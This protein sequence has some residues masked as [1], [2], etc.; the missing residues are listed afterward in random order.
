[1]HVTTMFC[2]LLRSWQLSQ[3]LSH[4]SLRGWEMGSG[5]LL[6][7][8]EVGGCAQE[9]LIGQHELVMKLKDKRKR[10][11]SSI[12]ICFAFKWQREATLCEGSEI[13]SPEI[14]Q[15]VNRKHLGGQGSC[16]SSSWR[17][18]NNLRVGNG[19]SMC[20][21]QLSCC[22]GNRLHALASG[23]WGCWPRVRQFTAGVGLLARRISPSKLS[24][25]FLTSP[26]SACA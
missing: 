23:P 1:M 10:G 24:S 6:V 21:H 15:G 18:W 25:D 2:M 12:S 9:I 17:I 22:W 16:G 26:T 3:Q 5:A 13:T 8:G 4:T 20:S 19:R 7:Q 14:L 11:N